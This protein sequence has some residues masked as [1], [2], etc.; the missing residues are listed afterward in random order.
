MVECE[1]CKEWF[2]QQCLRVLQSIWK[3]KK[4][5][6]DGCVIHARKSRNNEC[7]WHGS[8]LVF[9]IIPYNCMYPNVIAI[10]LQLLCVYL[11]INLLMLLY[12]SHCTS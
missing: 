10:V 5:Q 6:H 8:Y 3:K 4:P 12:Y 7:C 11:A 1:V 9:F 2:H